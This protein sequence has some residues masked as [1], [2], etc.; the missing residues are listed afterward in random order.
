MIIN[1]YYNFYTNEVS[2]E[3]ADEL[4]A[5][6]DA[7]SALNRNVSSFGSSK[8]F[9]AV[10]NRQ[11][12]KPELLRRFQ[13]WQ[14]KRISFA[15][16]RAF[17]K[18]SQCCKGELIK[19]TEQAPFIVTINYDDENGTVPG[20]DS[21]SASEWESYGNIKYSVSNGLNKPSFYKGQPQAF[22]QSVTISNEGY[23][24]I[25]QRVA[26]K[27][28]VFT[29]EAFEIIDKWFLRPGNEMLLNYGW[30]VP[31]TS[32]ETA[33]DTIHAVIFNFNAT[34]TD[35][36]GWIVTVYG[37]AKGNLAIGL[38]LGAAADETTALNKNTGQTEIPDENVIPNLTTILKD[39]VN[40]I[41]RVFPG[42]E[43][44]DKTNI[45]DSSTDLDSDNRPYGVIYGSDIFPHGVGRL[46]FAIEKTPD[47]TGLVPGQ[48]G[49]APS[50]SIID[51]KNYL[52]AKIESVRDV[53]DDE[54]ENWLNSSL[55]R[56]DSYNK[57]EQKYKGQ[58]NGRRKALYEFYGQNNDF[59]VINLPEIGNDSAPIVWPKPDD[60][61]TVDL[62]VVGKQDGSEAFYKEVGGYA[63]FLSMKDPGEGGFAG[64][65]RDA[66]RRQMQETLKVTEKN[67]KIAQYRPP[68]GALRRK[69][70]SE[71]TNEGIARGTISAPS[72]EFL[73]NQKTYEEGLKAQALIVEQQLAEAQA[74]QQ[75]ALPESTTINARIT[76]AQSTARYYICLGDLV[77][78]FN[79]KV[80]KQAPELYTSVQLLVENQ[81]TSYDPNLVSCIPMDV[82]LSNARNNR[83]GM[84]SYGL[85][86]SVN[87][88]FKYKK[89][90]ENPGDLQTAFGCDG[91]DFFPYG[92]FNSAEDMDRH[93]EDW[94]IYLNE[95]E[96]EKVA[97]FNIAHIWVSVDIISQAY[98]E[99]LQG[100]A[101]DPQYRT[102]FD[103]FENIFSK[104][105]QAT[106]GAI[107]L[108]L[109]PDNNQ[110]YSNKNVDSSKLTI[111]NSLLKKTQM[112]RI[113]D[114]NFQV[115]YNLPGAPRSFDFKVNDVNATILRDV[116]ISLK[117]PS[118]L[119]TV[120][121]TYGRAG[122]NEEIVDV[123]DSADGGS[124]C[125]NDFEKLKQKQ[126]EI[127]RKL[128][129]I[130]DEVAY[131]LSKDNLEKL[132][133]ALGQY[134]N[135][136]QPITSDPS[137]TTKA[138]SVHQGWIY[139]KLY[140]VELQFKLD[141]LSGF[142]YGNKVNVINALPSR[143]ADRVFFTLVKI[144][145]EI[146]NNDW[147]TSLTAIARLKNS[148]G[149]IQLPKIIEDRPDLCDKVK[150]TNKEN[151]E[152]SN[153]SANSDN[154]INSNDVQISASPTVTSTSAANIPRAGIKK[155]D[156]S[157]YGSFSSTTSPAIV[158][159][160]DSP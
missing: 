146:S 158:S 62:F 81:P 145:H 103:F 75:S 119:Q 85:Y 24:G 68:K 89:T 93:R 54:I 70:L 5:R 64:S 39:E 6:M 92:E 29:R 42:I 154:S 140:P 128:T 91:V 153:N 33:T 46:K 53:S 124:I 135:N 58:N 74:L 112:F 26:I 61:Q 67:L 98:M 44:S 82:I 3:V 99:V 30:S 55:R 57:I 34:L 114:N 95:S 78:Y 107:Q 138:V 129:A 125:K 15:E 1:Q 80:L 60:P 47:E 8:Q 69:I 137:D 52:L 106:A 56:V 17:R 151:V 104:I 130:K 49:T 118:K 25:V 22:L 2:K 84:S 108:T 100:R 86:N 122:L 31:L 123:D 77:Y 126:E 113:V 147:V 101:L 141:G 111:E 160:I 16:V 152:T 72:A 73:K 79:E 156:T 38:A 27:M 76:D 20:T 132:V 148:N 32:M 144:E 105:A 149:L 109:I 28:R 66:Q 120:A 21:K 142:L 9:F 143:Y 10:K 18:V 59:G 7:L 71:V 127:V 4:I 102:V 36:M 13:E 110:L 43:E 37:I 65:M 121:Y 35:D 87:Y 14:N 136:P 150:E 157:Q 12:A 94:G 117:L 131:N 88:G 115:P 90:K 45:Y 50:Q 159:P 11:D 23:G 83:G 139:S 40:K 134:V 133:N 63:P 48:P 96:G 41:K 97:A 51:E 116:N 19:E 155:I